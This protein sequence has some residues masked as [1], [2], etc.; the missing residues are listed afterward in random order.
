MNWEDK[1]TECIREHTVSLG[2]N[3]LSELHRKSFFAPDQS[4][5]KY[6]LVTGH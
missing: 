2:K 6:I 4:G 3:L 5:T 1:T